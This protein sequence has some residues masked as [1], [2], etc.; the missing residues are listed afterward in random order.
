MVGLNL[1]GSS[2]WGVNPPM[3]TLLDRDRKAS[4]CQVSYSD[5]YKL[6]K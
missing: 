5:A 1:G 4:K 2:D 3:V 6:G